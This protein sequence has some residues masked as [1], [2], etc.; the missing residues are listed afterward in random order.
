MIHQCKYCDYESPY[1]PNMRRHEKSKHGAQEPSSHQHA[2][3]NQ[4]GVGK[5]NP[6][7]FSLEGVTYL[8]KHLV[9]TRTFVE[10]LC[11]Y[12][13][14]H[15]QGTDVP[16]VACPDF[17]CLCNSIN[18]CAQSWSSLQSSL[19]WD[20]ARMF[21]ELHRHFKSRHATWG[22]SMPWARMLS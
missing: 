11:I 6:S 12:D 16:H 5:I 21:M 7:K 10:C 20:C 9:N 17:K 15:A 22:K 4:S 3:A 13:N 14:I 2:N 18:I 1:R 8:R 19:I